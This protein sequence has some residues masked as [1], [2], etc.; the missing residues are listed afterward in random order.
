MVDAET[1]DRTAG[2]SDWSVLPAAVPGLGA[3]PS[4]AVVCL[5]T[6]TP[7][8]QFVIGR[9][10]GDRRL[11]VGGG[12]SDGFKHANG[13]GEVL[14]DLV[15]G[16]ESAIDMGFAAPRPIRLATTGAPGAP[17]TFCRVPRLG[18]LGKQV[19]VR[20]SERNATSPI[21]VEV[22]RRSRVSEHVDVVVK[23]EVLAC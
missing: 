15:C 20:S 11:V 12:C 9:P 22:A 13:I 21:G 6:R 2:E 3:T 1:V 16:K 8:R 23:S 14:A 19:P 18:F 10:R 7:D 17:G 4:R 5:T